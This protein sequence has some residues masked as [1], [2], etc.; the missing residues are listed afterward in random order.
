MAGDDRQPDALSGL[1]ERVA[2]FH[3][4]AAPEGRGPRR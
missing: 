2:R 4:G 1:I 3:G